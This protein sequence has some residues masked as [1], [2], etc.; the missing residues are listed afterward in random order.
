VYTIAFPSVV[1]RGGACG[2]SVPGLLLARLARPRDNPSLNQ[3]ML[4]GLSARRSGRT[5]RT[6][7]GETMIHSKAPRPGTPP[8]VAS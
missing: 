7:M 3:T 1:G 8:E 4:S 2:T 6:A 5:S